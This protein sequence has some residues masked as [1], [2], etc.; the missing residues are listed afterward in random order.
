MYSK[1]AISAFLR[2]SKIST[3]SQSEKG[4]KTGAKRQKGIRVILLFGNNVV[5]VKGVRFP[6]DAPN[7]CLHSD[8]ITD[9]IAQFITIRRFLVS[10][11][12]GGRVPGG[13]RG[14]R[15]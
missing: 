1:M 11:W 7:Y 8:I 5:R 2:V 15:T 4:V 10:N 9:S 6:T 13:Y 14:Y 12:L 3:A